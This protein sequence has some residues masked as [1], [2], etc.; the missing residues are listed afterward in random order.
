MAGGWSGLHPAHV[1]QRHRPAG[2]ATPADD[3]GDGVMALAAQHGQILGALLAKSLVS[4]MVHFEVVC[5][6]ASPTA[7]A[8]TPK[9]FEACGG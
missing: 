1:D 5:G 6:I 4:A 2:I 9:R 7:V 3:V 8:I